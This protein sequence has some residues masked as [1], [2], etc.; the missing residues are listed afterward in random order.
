M[1]SIFMNNVVRHKKFFKLRLFEKN[2]FS[3]H[4]V[5]KLHKLNQ[6]SVLFKIYSHFY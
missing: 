6:I 4:I 3:E 2:S 1:H 5:D